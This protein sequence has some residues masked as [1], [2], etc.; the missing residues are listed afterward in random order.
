MLV[1]LNNNYLLRRT[2]STD[3]YEVPLYNAELAPPEVRGALVAL[4]QLAITFGIMVS[5]CKFPGTVF[6]CD[7]NTLYQGCRQA[8]R[9]NAFRDRLRNELHRRHRRRPIRR[10][11]AYPNL[12]S[13]SSFHRPSRWHATLYAAKP[14]PPNEPRKRA[15]MLGHPCAAS[16]HYNRG[17]Q[18]PYRVPRNQGSS[19]VRASA[20]RRAVSAVSRW[21]SEER[22]YDWGQ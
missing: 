9:Q 10:S 20:L 13:A 1:C 6:C 19:R 18:S 8:N 15:R 12:Y 11:L 5:Y 21:Q 17:H 2:T 3:S 16:K 4:Q 22:L 7:V 14:S